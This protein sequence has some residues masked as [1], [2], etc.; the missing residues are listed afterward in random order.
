MLFWN[1]PYIIVRLGYYY[2]QYPMDYY[3][4]GLY[5]PS[6]QG[7]S[8][9]TFLEG[10]SV[11]WNVQNWA[12]EIYQKRLW[13]PQRCDLFKN[14]L[15][16]VNSSLWF[17]LIPNFVWCN[18]ICAGGNKDISLLLLLF[19]I[20]IF[21]NAKY[22]FCILHLNGRSHFFTGEAIYLR[23]KGKRLKL[24]KVF[25]APKWALCIIKI[26]F[27]QGCADCCF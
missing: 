14:L 7:S 20:L 13:N 16:L 25:F 11:T 24:G 6:K 9:E 2:I 22:L 19:E 15:Q 5:F 17:P 10:F 3:I 4:F 12:S 21:A 27:I 1:T 8:S 26:C 23:N 18:I